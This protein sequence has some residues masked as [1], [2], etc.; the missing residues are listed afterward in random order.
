M[1]DRIA[2]KIA[3]N[4]ATQWALSQHRLDGNAWLAASAVLV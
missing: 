3:C 2:Q 1:P 4:A